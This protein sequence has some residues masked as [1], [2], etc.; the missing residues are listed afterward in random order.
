MELI[1][2]EL[3]LKK[4]AGA[5]SLFRTGKGCI[6]LVSGESGIG[7][8][9]LIKRFVAGQGQSAGVLWG[10]CDDMFSSRPLGP[11][12]DIALQ[13][14]SALLQLIPSGADRLTISS[15]FFIYLQKNPTPA[16]IVLED[17]HWVEVATLDMIKFSGAA[18]SR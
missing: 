16:I 7:K 5:W 4:L 14:E 13:V 8:T 6:A 3:Q 11:F 18:P 1:E 2:R 9:S 17:L 10:V 15:Q 12:L